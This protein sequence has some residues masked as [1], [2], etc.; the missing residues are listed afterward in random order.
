MDYVN[1]ITDDKKPMKSTGT[2][3]P[4]KI[5]GKLFSMHNIAHFLHLQTTSY[6]QHKMLDDVYN[7][8]VGSKDSIAEYLLGIQAPKRF[9][10]ITMDP[11]PGYS[12]GTVAAFLSQGFEF[13]CMLCEY[14]EQKELEELCNM[15]SDLQGIFVRA[16][17][18]NTLK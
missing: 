3:T 14:A 9:G 6:A 10:P 17:Y 16:R 4:E 8:L 15:A 11:I 5:V 7:G 12:E 2:L 13:T 18:L 1:Q